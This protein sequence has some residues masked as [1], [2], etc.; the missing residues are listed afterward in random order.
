MEQE[1]TRV[2]F[3]VGTK[4][5]VSIVS[6]LLGVILFL[7][8]STIIL[9]RE[10]KKAY[11]YQAQSVEALLA[12]KEFV[13]TAKHALQTLHMVLSDKEYITANTT[14]RN[15]EL[16]SI[17]ENQTE[18]IALSL[19][20]VDV[21]TGENRLRTETVQ[22]KYLNRTK[23]NM[24]NY[25]ISKDW[26]KLLLNELRTNKYGFINLSAVGG[27]PMLGIALTDIDLKENPAEI[28]IAVGLVSLKG[29]GTEGS[30]LK[31]TIANRSGWLL[32]DSDSASLFSKK[33]I[34]DNELFISALKEKLSNGA[35]EYSID[36]I[37]QLG[38]YS[39][40]DLNLVVL[41]SIEWQRAM[42][43]T[44]VLIEKFVLL[45]SMM[46]GGGVIFAILFAKSLT[47]PLE[48]LYEA[49]KEVAKGNFSLNLIRN[50]RDEIGALSSSFNTMSKKISALIIESMEKVKLENE[51][52]VASTVQ[53]TLIPPEEF[54]NDQLYIFSKYQSASQC[55]GDWWGFFCAHNKI[56]I[57]IADATGHGVPSALITASARSCFSVIHKI[58]QENPE[59]TFSPSTMLSYANRVIFEASKAEI[60]MTFFAG[61]FDFTECT[62]TY[63][64]AG[65]N[66]PWLYKKSETGFSSD[67][68]VANGQRL[69]EEKDAP[70]FE[71]KVVSIAEGDILFLYTDGLIEAQ[72][73]DK[74]VYGKKR[75]RRLIEKNVALGPKKIVENLS[76]DFSKFNE[77]KSLDDDVTLAVIQILKTK[78]GNSSHET[79]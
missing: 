46:I 17:I 50:S 52:A 45:G 76:V 39:L 65:H 48:Q 23:I 56:A 57:L 67:A 20:T 36:S 16:A 24:S 77:G 47:A 8:I 29:F 5:L 34:S 59:F 70:P 49:T 28:P 22:E 37:S 9:F 66:P 1:E 4:L 3:S 79:S 33:N 18:I 60:M 13:S 78:I 51:L 15:E 2:T 41:V 35:M 63:S 43:A 62:L 7:N 54:R 69:G 44:Y 6:I 71:E 53:Q 11:I 61:V 72:N 14:D 12:G 10:D 21:S 27:E 25:R 55:G 38:S 73:L 30:P 19:Y 64:S 40:P 42:R 32:Y 74:E 58:A 75:A 68:L 31:L 26:M